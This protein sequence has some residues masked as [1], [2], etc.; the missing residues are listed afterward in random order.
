MSLPP[1]VLFR[2]SQAG[3][4]G[5]PA[6]LGRYRH[7]EATRVA[8]DKPNKN[9]DWSRTKSIVDTHLSK[10]LHVHENPSKK[11]S[12][13]ARYTV[14]YIENQNLQDSVIPCPYA[15]QV[16]ERSNPSCQ[17]AI[18]MSSMCRRSNLLRV[19]PTFAFSGSKAV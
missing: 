8:A 17:M 9:V 13:N 7:D 2:A 12:R 3:F 11:P 19:P 4:K 1:T 10:C 18:K 6:S 16:Q 5:H 15:V 14:L